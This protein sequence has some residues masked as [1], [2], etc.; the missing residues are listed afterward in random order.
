[1]LSERAGIT[2]SQA[3]KSWPQNEVPQARFNS[4]SVPY[5]VQSHVRNAAAA[6]S[7]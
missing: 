5:R 3:V 1:M 4:A 2:W 7:Q 6:M